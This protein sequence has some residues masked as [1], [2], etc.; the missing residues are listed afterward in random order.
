M[1]REE[2]KNKKCVDCSAS[3]W[4]PTKLIKTT[5]EMKKK[6]EQIYEKYFGKVS[7]DE[8]VEL[9]EY[10]NNKYD[11]CE[12]LNELELYCRLS[13]KEKLFLAA[14]ECRQNGVLKF[15]GYKE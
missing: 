1:N 4:N 3:E 6:R 12:E 14:D 10:I 13:D 11:L 15:L 8:V 7:V 5:P 9:I 2:F